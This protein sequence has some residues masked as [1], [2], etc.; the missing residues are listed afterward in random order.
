[1]QHADEAE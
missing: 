1:M